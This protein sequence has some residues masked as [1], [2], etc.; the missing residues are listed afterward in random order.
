METKLSGDGYYAFDKEQM[1]AE[2]QKSTNLL[3]LILKSRY[4]IL[5]VVMVLCGT[6][7][8][9]A[10]ASL[11][12]SGEEIL[13][14]IEAGAMA[15]S[16]T[17]AAPRG[18]IT[19]RNGVILASSE[20]VPTVLLAEAGLND[21]DL[22]E[23]LLDLSYLFDQ[24]NVV[25]QKELSE[26]LGITPSE[27][28]VYQFFVSQD[29]IIAWQV[30]NFELTEGDTAN[31][32]VSASDE[33]VKLD[34]QIFFMFL[35]KTLFSIDEKYSLEDAYR[36]CILRYQIYKENWA[37]TGQGKPVVIATDVPQEL[38]T[39]LLE[40]NYKYK[41]IIADREY[42]RVYS[43]QAREASHVMGYV[44]NISQ[45]TFTSVQNFGYTASDVI[46]QTGIEWQMERYLHGQSGIKPYNIITATEESWQFIPENIGKDA[47]AGATVVLTLDA[48][49]QKI[50]ADALE[51][52]I[53]EA[54]ERSRNNPKGSVKGAYAG[55]LVLMDVKTGAIL[56]MVS[57]PD[58]DPADFVLAMQNDE[59]AQERVKKYLSLDV[60]E[61]N[62]DGKESDKL[63]PLWNRAIMSSYAPGSTF[64]LVTAIAG[65]ETGQIYPGNT[66]IRCEEKYD[67]GGRLLYCN[68][69]GF[70]DLQ[71]AL[72]RSCNMYME[73]LGERS[74]INAIDEW[75]KKLGLG[76]YTGIDLPGEVKGIRANRENKRL[77][78][79]DPQDRVWKIADTAQAAIGQIYNSY[80]II[81]L[82]RY[83]TA[84]STNQLVTPHV[85]QEV[86]ASDGSILY[87][88]R[89]DNTP[90]GMSQSTIDLVQ[91]SM[92]A[93]VEY[94]SGTAYEYM[95]GMPFTVAGK[96]GTAE[97][98]WEMK[99][100]EE[101][102]ESNG[103]FV[104]T[105]SEHGEEPEVALALIVERGNWGS[106]TTEI[107][108]KVLMAYFGYQDGAT[109][110]E[111][112]SNPII[113]DVT[114]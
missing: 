78:Q 103:L 3:T 42:R 56:A 88:P 14:V 6:I 92:Q 63:M 25:P 73:K 36:I 85:I 108:R 64:K 40:Q 109:E 90:I 77:I 74:S 59:M 79:P 49:L 62:E 35:R 65:L 37:F 48:N 53:F 113:G 50:A 111:E 15:R 97:T 1:T 89:M 54:N 38:I 66:L 60:E 55:A 80:S 24:F 13:S 12:F 94:K 104:C 52:Y 112:D 114:G 51:E 11:Q 33:Y 46:G 68:N 47:S 30:R 86:I 105:A 20:E 76:E 34:P 43:P 57:F 110:A 58:Y 39:L 67:F 18:N 93:V 96:T 71:S 27:D 10:T 19:D 100:G 84:V 21:E 2:P 41:G 4:T 83:V 26:Y 87:Q 102:E 106:R 82:A 32:L 17:T 91:E 44:G 81:Q 31:R 72:A 99:E 107:A 7:I 45:E 5:G 16:Y 29:E 95:S 61:S 70:Q 22:N 98:G 69:H 23:M 75:G 101:A 8:L 9:G 28:N